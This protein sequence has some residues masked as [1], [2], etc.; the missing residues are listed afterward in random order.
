MS[1]VKNIS[2]TNRRV[3]RFNEKVRRNFVRFRRR[4]WS[5]N[6]IP[7]CT[8]TRVNINIFGK[9]FVSSFAFKRS[10][11]SAVEPSVRRAELRRLL[12]FRDR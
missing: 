3:I 7:R 4:F 11:R 1:R 6:I 8:T 10:V 2:L 12:I 5:T 9:K